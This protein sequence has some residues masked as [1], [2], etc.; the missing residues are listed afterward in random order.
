MPDGRPAY[1]DF[2]GEIHWVQIDLAEAAE[3]EDHFLSPEQQYRIAMARQS[4]DL[5]RYPVRTSWA[6]SSSRSA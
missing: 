2:T 1:V 3:D 5:N 4:A 6:V